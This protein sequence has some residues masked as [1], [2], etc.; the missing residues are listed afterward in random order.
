[1]TFDFDREIPRAGTASVKHDGAAAN[2]G[3]ADL[4]PM[5]VADMDFAAPEAITRALMARAAHSIYGY[6]FYPDSM[7]EALGKSV[8]RAA[9]SQFGRQITRGILGGILKGR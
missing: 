3:S 4:I 2:F 9:G 8:I 7:Y 5:W 1:M 6:T